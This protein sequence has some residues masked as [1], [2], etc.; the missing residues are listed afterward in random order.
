MRIIIVT[1]MPGT[2]KE[3][4]LNVALEK[5]VNFLRMGDLVRELHAVRSENDLD[6]NIG[7][8]A[9]AERE[10]YGYDIWAKR[11]L[12][13]M[14]GDLFLIDG[15][16]S[17]DEV[18]AYQGLSDDV[19]IIA[20]HS[21]PKERYKRLVARGRDDAPHN[22]DEFNER[23]NRE[24]GWGVSDVIALADYMIVND[25]KLDKFKEKASELFDRLI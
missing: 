8:F 20:I 10:R 2:G 5:H 24:M 17:M 3:E 9:T 21:P 19:E 14:S 13:R 4:L 15:C 12:E 25:E 22:I 18:R 6:L 1:G 11:A 23:D 7:Q 16:R